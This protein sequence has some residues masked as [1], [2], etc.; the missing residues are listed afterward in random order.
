[1]MLT[2]KEPEMDKFGSSVKE[3]CATGTKITQRMC[4]IKFRWTEVTSPL[5]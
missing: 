2:N 5:E 4:K 3:K 1:M